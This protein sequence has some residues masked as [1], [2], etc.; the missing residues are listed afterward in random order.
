[1]PFIASTLGGKLASGLRIA[2]FD[3]GADFFVLAD[4]FGADFLGCFVCFADGFFATGFFF[5]VFL[6]AMILSLLKK[7][8]AIL[9]TALSNIR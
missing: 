1:M 7:F 2:D 3:L 8:Y 6:V 4:F 5:V 9:R